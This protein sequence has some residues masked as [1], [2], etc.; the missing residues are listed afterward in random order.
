MMNL[1][2]AAIAL[3]VHESSSKLEAL[4]SGD[5]PQILALP[6]E[7][8]QSRKHLAIGQYLEVPLSNLDELQYTA[9]LYLGSHSSER[10]FLFDTGSNVL[11]FTSDICSES[12]DSCDN[13]L[14]RPYRIEDSAFGKFY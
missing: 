7:S 6:L 5:N 11:W 14:S 12:P 10:T 2:L 1:K 9:K 3:L 8:E 4:P 13:K